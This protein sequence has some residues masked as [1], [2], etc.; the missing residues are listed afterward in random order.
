M[1]E[2]GLVGEKLSHSYSPEIHKRMAD[3]DYKLIEVARDE[4]DSFF[5]KKEFLGLNVTI[6]YKQTV[7]PHLDFIDEAARGIGAVNTV[8]NDGGTL[9]GYNTDW[10][11]MQAAILR[12]GIVPAG[13]KVL[14][15]GTGGTSKTAAYVAS[16]LGASETVF[17]SRTGRNGAATYEEAYRSHS[18]AGI[19]INT[20]PSGMYPHADDTP[21]DISRFPSLSGVFDAIY[22]PIRTNLVVEATR[23]GIPAAGG[24]YMLVFQA[25]KASELFTGRAC[26]KGLAD[27]ICRELLREKEN[28]VLIGMPSSGKTSVGK[29]LAERLGRELVDTDEL[30]K[31]AEGREISDIFTEHGEEYFRNAERNAVKSASALQGKVIATGGGAVLNCGNVAALKRGGRIY[32]LDRPLELLTAT[33]DRPLSSDA[34]SLKARY[35]ER[36]AIYRGA[37]DVTV[38]SSGTVDEAARIIEEDF[39]S[40]ET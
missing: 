39:I 32:F 31:D 23:R 5:D 25:V 3:Y 33:S 12:A 1:T 16:Q 13:K 35:N 6:P 38:D 29:I 28:V 4:I 10:L 37:C 24:L 7:I 9:R 11:G 34:A 18:D 27:S 17:L 2:Y 15:C 26:S 8:V 22:N 36:I 21:I 30:I 19:I 14:I 40:R 20:T